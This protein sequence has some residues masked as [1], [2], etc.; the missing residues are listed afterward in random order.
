MSLG[1]KIAHLKA[2]KGI[3]S[4]DLAELSGVPIG[5]LNKILNG[6]RKNPT[7]RTLGKLAT[8]LDCTVE[9]L[10]GREDVEIKKTAA[11]NSD[12]IT[13]QEWKHIE[14][15]RAASPELQAAAIAML[16]AAERA[17]LAQDSSEA[18]E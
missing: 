8:A 1:E 6:E 9:Y 11:I 5:T 18:S 4:K 10:Y 13:E 7:G 12:G 14:L 16:E 15:F 3:T 17:R 2:A